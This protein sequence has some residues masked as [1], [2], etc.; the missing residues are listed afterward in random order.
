MA[1]AIAAAQTQL[2]D[3]TQANAERI[4]DASE[5]IVQEIRAIDIPDPRTD[6]ILAALE[7]T[8]TLVVNASESIEAEVNQNNRRINT[9]I[10]EIVAASRSIEAEVNQNH[11]RINTAID[12]I[13]AASKSIEAEVNQ[14]NRRINTAIDSIDASRNA[15]QDQ[16]AVLQGVVDDVATKATT[17][18][19]TVPTLDE[20]LNVLMWQ[21]D[22]VQKNVIEHHLLNGSSPLSLMLPESLGG[23]LEQVRD[24]V[25]EWITQAAQ[26]GFD[27]R[28]AEDKF[29][30][31]VQDLLDGKYKDAYENFSDAYKEMTKKQSG[32]GG[33]G[34][35]GDD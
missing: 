35:G 34:G 13:V 28:K 31:G 33:G 24:L 22:E 21:V 5:S 6:E 30:D 10:D 25:L 23:K 11:R 14:N 20:K 29:A 27:V 1:D 4:D 16:I 7:L 12:K 3:E 17:I 18:A 19:D 8:D 15:I 9:A 2:S 32:R 26:A